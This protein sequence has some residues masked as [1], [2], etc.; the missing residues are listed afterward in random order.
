MEFRKRTRTVH[1]KSAYP[2]YGAAIVFL[3]WSLLAPVYKLWVILLAALTAAGAYFALDKFFFPGRDEIV[4]EE[5]LTGDRELDEFIKQARATLKRFRA[6]A[7]QANDRDVQEKLV[8]IVNSTESIVDEV[9]RDPNDRK[10]VYTF[11]SYYLPAIDK[12]VGYYQT[13]LTAGTGDYVTE[14]KA[15]IENSLGMVAE[16]FEKQLDRLF[17]NEALDVKTDITLMET[18]LRMDGLTDKMT[19]GKGGTTNG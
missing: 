19:T 13:F 16:A 11:F 17:H 12:L 2:I 14:G 6:M 9:V 7:E 4:E 18:M 10:D 8:R 15:R 3:L 1:H 5:V